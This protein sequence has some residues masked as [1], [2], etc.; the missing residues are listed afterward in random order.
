MESALVNINKVLWKYLDEMSQKTDPYIRSVALDSSEAKKASIWSSFRDGSGCLKRYYAKEGIYV[1]FISE[2]GGMFANSLSFRF[3]NSLSSHWATHY[4]YLVDEDDKCVLGLAMS[5][6]YSST[7]K[8]AL[9]SIESD[10]S[11]I[12]TASREYCEENEYYEDEEC[13]K[14]GFE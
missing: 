4:I 10:I 6:P 2:I 14:E 11:G 1:P 12:E 13:S 8:S 7:L 3:D 5:S 9:D